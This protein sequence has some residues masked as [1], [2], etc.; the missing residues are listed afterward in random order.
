M[1]VNAR[2]RLQ[3]SPQWRNFANWPDISVAYLPEDKR[4]GF[5][6]NV[7]IIRM[8]LSGSRYSDIA[9]KVGISKGQISKLLARTLAGNSDSEPALT[10]ACIPYYPTQKVR[11]RSPLSSTEKPV[12]ARA[13]FQYLLETVPALKENLDKTIRE[14]IKDNPAGQNLTPQSFHGA[15][16]LFLDQ[17]HHPKDQYPYTEEQLGYESTRQYLHRRRDELQMELQ[18]A[19]QPKRVISPLTQPFLYGREIQIDEERYDAKVSIHL[20]VESEFIP[21]RMARLTLVLMSD[22]DT[23]TAIARHLALKPEASQYDVLTV[24]E[25][26]TQESPLPELT[27]PGLAFAPGD[28]FP[29][30]LEGEY[31]RVAFNTVSLD[32]ALA[33]HARSIST[34]V[35]KQHGGTVGA[36]L[37]AAP[38]A[39]H[40]VERAFRLLSKQAK[41]HKSTSGKN[42]ADPIKESRKNAKKP[43]VLTLKALEDA[44]DVILARHNNTAQPQLYGSTPLELCRHHVQTQF[45]RLLPTDIWLRHQPFELR[46]QATVKWLKHEHRSAHINFLYLRYQGNCINREDLVNQQVELRYDFRDIR[47]LDVYTL[48]GEYV[49]EVLAPK[50]WQRFSHT[51]KTRQYIHKYCRLKRIK[52]KD[53]LAEFFWLQV[54]RKNHEKSA[55]MIA[56][57]FQEYSL[58]PTNDMNPTPDTPLTEVHEVERQ[59]TH[60]IHAKKSVQPWSLSM[61]NAKTQQESEDEKNS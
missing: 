58:F 38:K 25:K 28:G 11:R 31:T 20:D 52:M 18:I 39:R 10:K 15:F 29:C 56:N 23:G 51:V 16:I 22:A 5:L 1:Y 26:A 48:T 44:I 49:G 32:N 2:Q 3:A 21:L 6:R 59:P 40:V 54:N 33:H 60:S 41:R 24:M 42:P 45:I 47:R 50:S 19:R 36:G 27:T 8:V 43:P 34:L 37:P 35:C 53:P 14:D 61:A 12:G 13:S 4:R 46:Q 30:N 57:L 55:L 9:Q 17:A 7:R